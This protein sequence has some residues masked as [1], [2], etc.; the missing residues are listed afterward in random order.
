LRPFR[1]SSVFILL[2]A[3]AACARPSLGDGDSKSAFDNKTWEEQKASLPS[4]PKTEN[5]APIYVG[6]TAYGFLVDTT[7]IS[8]NEDGTIRYTLIAR[9]SSGAMNVSYESIRC[10][11]YERRLYA[12]GR[13]GGTWSQARNSKW[14][15][16]GGAQYTTLA[17]D[18]FC[19]KRGQARA[20]ED[21]V[22]LLGRSRGAA[23]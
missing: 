9:S 18:F 5:L 20:A 6:P 7:S 17:D 8:V 11:T 19:A 4:F 3:L 13:S 21:V 10:G 1:G 16:I 23:R 22:D 2:S 14:V 15:P 12:L